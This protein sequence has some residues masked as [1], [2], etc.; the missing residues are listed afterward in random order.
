MSYEKERP[1]I[2]VRPRFT[3]ICRFD[4]FRH[5]FIHQTTTTKTV[6]VVH[7]RSHA[8]PPRRSVLVVYSFLISLEID[9]GVLGRNL[10]FLFHTFQ[11]LLFWAFP[12]RVSSHCW[13]WFML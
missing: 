4:S 13:F 5:G 8:E 7:A 2:G 3:P 9:I 1:R 6:L 11:Y 12:R 10:T